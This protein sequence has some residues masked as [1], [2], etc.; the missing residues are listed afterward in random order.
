MSGDIV[1]LR[2][3]EVYVNNLHLSS[4]PLG[5]T[6]YQVDSKVPIDEFNPK[7]VE[8]HQSQSGDTTTYFIS[9][10]RDEVE[11]LMQRK[12]EVI[13]IKKYTPEDLF[14][15]LY[16]RASPEGHWSLDNYGPLKIP[17][18]GDSIEVN[19][20]NFRLYHNV[21]E[22]HTGLNVIKEKLY[23]LMGDNRHNADDSRFIGLISHSKMYGIV[24]K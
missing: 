23:F 7:E 3:G 22:V 16:A 4:P 19:E 12:Q 21:P 14:D 15:T 11:K 17:S 5:K 24:V 9:L 13:A 18:P 8:T 10:T 20:V 6:E 2:R 1:E